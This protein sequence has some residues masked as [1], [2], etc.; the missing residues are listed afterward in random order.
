M[1]RKILLILLVYSAS[2][3][4][5]IISALHAAE[6]RS[7]DTVALI[8]EEKSG[9][10]DLYVK[11][12]S[13]GEITIDIWFTELANARSSMPLPVRM[14]VK[15]GARSKALRVEQI[16]KKANWNSRFL[17]QWRPGSSDAVHDDKCVY[18]LPYLEGKFFL[19]IQGYNGRITHMGEYEYSIDWA[20][21]IGTP[22]V[23][24]RGGLV[25][26]TEDRY[27]GNGLID[28]YR[29]KN[30]YVRVRH[31]DGTMGVY[32]HL[33]TGGIK[34]KKGQLVRP[35]DVLGLSGNV[36]YS[37]VPHLHF[38]VFTPVDGKTIKTIPVKF[39]TGMH[40]TVTLVEG[41]F[42]NTR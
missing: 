28:E 5:E 4:M 15:G 35:G 13:P 7:D 2:F 38:C 17:Y 29:N 16:D 25:T 22:V 1:I 23:A 31:D 34:V 6:F 40:G 32:V 30:N 42:Y 39:E 3:Y 41:E 11:N 20:M 14:I 12:S 21:P 24:A 37:D 19:V 18:R 33:N 36:G 8:T 26:D 27:S 9:Y 10:Y